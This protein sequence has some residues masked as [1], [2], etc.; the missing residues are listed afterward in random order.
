MARFKVEI[1]G[2]NTNELKVLTNEEMIELFKRYKNGDNTA[3]EEL[4]NGNLKLVLSILKYF[5]HGNINLDDLFQVG[6]IGLILLV[7][8][9]FLNRKEL[10]EILGNKL[11]NKIR[12]KKD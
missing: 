6:V 11:L 7:L 3:K 10:E 4:V 2:I 8:Y 5:N 12:R 1:T 9:Y